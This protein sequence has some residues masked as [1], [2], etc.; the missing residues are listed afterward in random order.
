LLVED[1]PGVGK[2]TLV[3]T[4]ARVLGLESKRVQFTND[5]LPA[6]ILGTAIFDNLTHTFK[7]LPGPV[8]TH[9]LIADELNRGTPRTQ[10][11][12]LQ[13]MEE[14]RISME[15]MT[16]DLP[17]PFFVVATQNPREQI[18][19][20]PLP[21]SQLDRFLLRIHM[22]FPS[23]QYE[24]ELLKGNRKQSDEVATVLRHDDLLL[25]Q[26]QCANVHCSDL[27]IKYVQRILL[28]SRNVRSE[29]AG[30]SPRSG[31]ALLAVARAWAFLDGRDFVLPEDVQNV[32]PW[33]INH[34]MKFPSSAAF[35]K[36]KE[37]LASIP[38]E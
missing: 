31:L 30:L 20:Y 23:P 4:L 29:F 28:H 25:L 7:F 6:D 3:K 27:V 33:A 1:V 15:G 16:R 22:G 38:V 32:G 36:S 37:F 2:T 21:E 19:T 9:C 26:R 35:E 34:R 11:A 17:D 12:F 18:G 14:R 13:A 8:F 24:I 5:L 10:S